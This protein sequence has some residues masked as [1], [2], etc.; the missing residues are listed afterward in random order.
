MEA[1]RS[2]G[3][4]HNV[5]MRKIILPQAIRNCLPSLGNEFIALIKETSVVSFITVMDLYSAFRAIATESFAYKSVYLI[6]GVVYF[7]IIFIISFLLKK[8]ERRLLKDD[9]AK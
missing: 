5:V 6:M 3:L 2:L 7:V 9:K 8:I 4:P 1:G